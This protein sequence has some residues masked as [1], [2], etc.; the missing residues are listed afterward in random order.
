MTAGGSLTRLFQAYDRSADSN[1]ARIYLEI[2]RSFPVLVVDAAVTRVLNTW[3]RVSLPPV[4]IL[5]AACL[6]IAAEDRKHRGEQRPPKPEET[7][8]T[9]D[10]RA[11]CR[12]M[13][14]LF[15]AGL[16]WCEMLG[17]WVPAGQERMLWPDNPERQIPSL[18]DSREAVEQLERGELVGD[19]KVRE[20]RATNPRWTKAIDAWVEGGAEIK[21][22][23]DHG[24]EAF[25]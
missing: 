6:E 1:R 13:R 10:D 17:A 22:P 25:E 18:A 24:A 19:A 3:T 4:A 11:H 15:D 2:V 21:A 12:V 7:P 16:A 8:W 14:R 23:R 5:R 20:W 9:E